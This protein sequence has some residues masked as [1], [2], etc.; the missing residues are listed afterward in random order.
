MKLE[1][2]KIGLHGERVESFTGFM[3]IQQDVKEVNF[4]YL[5]FRE[6]QQRR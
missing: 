5:Y 1:W 3:I 4:L 2:E 6:A